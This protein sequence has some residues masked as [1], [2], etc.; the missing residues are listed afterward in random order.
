MLWKLKNR[1]RWRR[2]RRDDTNIETF[3]LMA[4]VYR[5]GA[6]DNSFSKESIMSVVS[7][8]GRGLGRR[9]EP[10]GTILAVKIGQQAPRGTAT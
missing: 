9:P 7:L 6:T 8:L 2:L 1:A 4:I 10:D 5:I 3:T